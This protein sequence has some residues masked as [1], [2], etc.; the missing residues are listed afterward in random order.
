VAALLRRKSGSATDAAEYKAHT[1]RA[2]SLAADKK[3]EDIRAYD[4]HGL[5][6]VADSFVLCTVGSEPQ[7][8]AVIGNVREGMREA[9]VRLLHEE[10]RNDGGWMLLDF[11]S[12]ILHVFRK[13]A[14]EFYDLDGLWAD[15]PA[16]PLDLEP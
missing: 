16:I 14:R 8:K 1:L 6:V 7:M 3:A 12:V 13:D 15:A 11:G 2:A 9:G 4:I 10:G 5:T